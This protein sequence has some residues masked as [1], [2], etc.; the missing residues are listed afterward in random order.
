MERSL[1]AS[2]GEAVIATDL[3][4]G[5]IYWNRAA[6]TLYGWRADEVL[7][8]NI[9]DVTPT[10]L[11][12][13][14]AAAIFAD[15]MQGRTW[16]GEF[17]ARC[18]NGRELTVEVTDYPVRDRENRLFAIVG[19]SR[20]AKPGRAAPRDSAWRTLANRLRFDTPGSG[21]P[22]EWTMLA[23]IASVAIALRLLLDMLIPGQLPFITYFPAMAIAGF[24]LSPWR[25]ALLLA[26][27]AAAGFA[28]IERHNIHDPLVTIS[29]PAAFI[30]MSAL[31]IAMFSHVA[32][33]NRRL[34]EREER[35]A[36]LNGE[37]KHRIKNLFALT[38]SVALRTLRTS[39]SLPDAQKAIVG[40][41]QAIAAAQELSIGSGDGADLLTLIEKVVAPIAPTPDRIRIDGEGFAL[42]GADAT[43]FSLLLH[44]LATNAIKY[45]AWAG[46]QG[47]VRLSW[48]AQGA[49]LD[50]TW[51]ERGAAHDAAAPTREGFGAVL[52]RRAFPN[53][54]IR[55]EIMP[56]G[57]V[58]SVTL[59]GP[60]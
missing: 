30:V 57:A 44:E 25:S 45:G 48:R 2:L 56:E 29:A 15:L 43:S 24:L 4:G 14:A 36:L 42:S 26:I 33:L 22:R 9:L 21:Q 27:L 46:P 41:I 52:M 47:E 49:A 31:L 60:A 58:C 34:R 40:R 32:R 6:E 23:A 51:I 1:L 53:A 28:W 38:T 3:H 8:A 55:H 17:K 59:P 10:S 12:R 35:L 50:F 5:I 37:L 16:S 13:D 11:S 18:K 19:V 54:V 7:G 39:R 20:L